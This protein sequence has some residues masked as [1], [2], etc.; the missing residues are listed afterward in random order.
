MKY[1]I[2]KYPQTQSFLFFD[3]N[4][5]ADED[6]VVDLC[7]T[8]IS[9][10]LQRYMWSSLCRADQLTEKMANWM[11]KAGCVKIMF[12]VETG[13]TELMKTLMKKTSLEQIKQTIEMVTKKG[14]DAV[15][16][17]IIG[18]PGETVESIKASY[19]FAKKL[20][21]QST[22]W[23]IMQVYPGTGLSR[24]Q[25]CEDF[26]AYLY[27]PEVNNPCSSISACIPAYINPNLDREK[28]K[29]TYYKIYKD[30][31]LY[32]AI[33]HPFFTLKKIFYSPIPAVKF[34]LGLIKRNK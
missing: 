20:K 23:G 28:M 34:L 26:V 9:E 33:T 13:D 6:R 12:G 19:N 27:K 17:F 18:T 4:F 31:A 16:F 29:K 2:T 15:A 11:K 14:I 8:I 3:D 32:K 10:G 30:I 22:A 7:K 24:L 25:P 5:S 21:C 1:L